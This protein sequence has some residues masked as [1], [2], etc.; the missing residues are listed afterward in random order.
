LRSSADRARKDAEAMQQRGQDYLAT[1]EKE[2]AQV[3]D[4]QMRS[5]AAER[6]VAVRAT[7]RAIA[8]TARGTQAS[9]DSYMKQLQEIQKAL[10][11]DLTPGGL[12]TV[13]PAIQTAL[14]DGEALRQQLRAQSGQ[15]DGVYAGMGGG[16]ASGT[17]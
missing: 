14:T 12:N 17:K 9:Y 1:W 4:P 7:Y 8:E 11:N 3:S 15:I 6:Q 16:K 13:R 2:M 10:A 5:S